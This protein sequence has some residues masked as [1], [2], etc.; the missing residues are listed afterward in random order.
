MKKRN[1]FIIFIFLG[2]M[3]FAWIKLIPSK[4][5]ST[6]LNIHL[7]NN[8][9][10]LKTKMF[11]GIYIER[12]SDGIIYRKTQFKNGL[13]DGLSEQFDFEGR[14]YFKNHYR[15]GLLDGL[16]E[17]WYLE[18]PKKSIGHFKDGFKDGEQIEWHLNGSLFRREVFSAGVETE[19]KMLYTTGEIFSNYKKRN[20]IA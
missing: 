8:K 10:Y 5:E 19:R 4:I 20:S 11:T 13:K 9:L 14:R 2:C 12:Y 7:I 6:N 15:K 3:V 17:T 18:G 16:Q 1:F